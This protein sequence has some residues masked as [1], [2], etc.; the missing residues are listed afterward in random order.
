[1]ACLVQGPTAGSRW[2]WD[3]HIPST[4]EAVIPL[5]LEESIFTPPWDNKTRGLR[6][7]LPVADIQALSPT[8][9]IPWGHVVRPMPRPGTWVPLGHTPLALEA[10][11]EAPYALRFLLCAGHIM[12]ASRV[13]HGLRKGPLPRVLKYEKPSP[14]LNC[15]C[16]S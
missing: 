10:L 3:P 16:S 2:S 12:M 8:H 9:C 4:A 15:I 11:S 14:R 13:C 5:C 7:Q 1:M 6:A